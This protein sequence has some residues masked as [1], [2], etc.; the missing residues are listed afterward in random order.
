MKSKP[1]SF[2]EHIGR[3][4]D[5][6]GVRS[7]TKAAFFAL[8]VWRGDEV[9]EVF[10]DLADRSPALDALTPEDA[11]QIRATVVE[12][13][14]PRNHPLWLAGHPPASLWHPRIA[15]GRASGL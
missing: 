15:E 9:L 5:E 3:I 7:D 11:A 4:L 10:A 6:Y 8:Y 1:V 13:Y 12:R 14:P 2:P